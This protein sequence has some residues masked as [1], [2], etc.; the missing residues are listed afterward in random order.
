MSAQN[1]FSSSSANEVYIKGDK[2][3]PPY[4]NDPESY[5]DLRRRQ[6]LKREE[7]LKNSKRFQR[8]SEREDRTDVPLQARVN[9]SLGKHIPTYRGFDICK[10]PVDYVLYRQLFELVRPKT[11][12]ELGTLSGGMAVWISDTL[13]L[14]DV[15]ANVYSMD[16]DPSNRSELVNKLK[17]ENVTFLQG[18]SHKIE[19][20]FTDE[21]MKSLPHPW[22]FSEDAHANLDGVLEHFHRYMKEGDYMVV[23]DTGP[24][25]V[26]QVDSKTD[27][28]GSFTPVGP[29]QLQCFKRFLQ[30]HEEFYAV[31]SF[32]TDMYGYNCSWHW[33]GFVKRMK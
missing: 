16:I 7:L 15:E 18:D 24:D 25:L 8:I 17:P 19:E 12:I 20:T 32:L 1:S 14:L 31:D 6:A 2:Y 30:D 9:T 22:V 5:K 21:F 10:C 26:L 13:G 29:K 11:V 3:N 27:D 4:A 33:H 23:E 28:G